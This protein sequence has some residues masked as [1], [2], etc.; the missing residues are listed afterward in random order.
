MSKGFQKTMKSFS[1]GKLKTP[2]GRVVTDRSEAHKM[3]CEAKKQEKKA[4]K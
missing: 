3:A 4:S 2:R 1:S